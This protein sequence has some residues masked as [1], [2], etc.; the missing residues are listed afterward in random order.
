M[1]GDNICVIHDK[2]CEIN[3]K[4]A[5]VGVKCYIAPVRNQ[6]GTSHRSSLI[7]ALPE[8]GRKSDFSVHCGPKIDQ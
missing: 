5:D 6:L 4:S 1:R 7:M 3:D 8:L 2:I